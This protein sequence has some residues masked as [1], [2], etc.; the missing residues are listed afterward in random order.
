V[1]FTSR[2]L[3]GFL[4]A[5][6]HLSFTRAAE[7]LFI[8]P[9]GLSVLVRELERQ[10]GFRLFERTT[11]YVALTEHGRR[12][13]PVARRAQLTHDTLSVGAGLLMAANVLPQAIKEFQGSWPETRIQL[14]D[15]GPAAIMERVAARTLDIGLGFFKTSPGVR[16]IPFFRFSLM[17]I[18]PDA[19]A[20]PRR[21]SITWSALKGERLVLQ[22]PPAPVSN[23]IDR[24]LV[25]AGIDTR[26]AI[27]LNRL[28]TVI[29][30][31]EAGAG[32]GIVPSFALP[33]CRRRNVTASQLNSPTVPVD[34]FQIRNRGRKLPLVAEEFGEFLQ[35]YIARWAGSTGVL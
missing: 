25:Q 33:V 31:V 8:T 2:Q 13:L 6:Q 35:A 16:R 4:L 23:L 1:D 10:V 11:R 34:L 21:A 17:V 14:F 19:D 9:S 30:M 7:Q 32:T 27:R 12:L 3:N 20:G 26:R 24:H 22:A 18:R 5:A 28:E 15:A 29:A